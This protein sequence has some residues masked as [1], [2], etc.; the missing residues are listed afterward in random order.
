MV[1]PFLS[2]LLPF[3]RLLASYASYPAYIVFT[4]RINKK[5]LKI[6]LN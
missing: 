4:G 5:P 6:A 1:R 3:V 2:T